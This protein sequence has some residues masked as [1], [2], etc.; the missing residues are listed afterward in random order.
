MST[1]RFAF[2]IFLTGSAMLSAGPLLV[3]LA[4]VDPL[5]SAFWR[6]GL[7]VPFL[8]ALARMGDRDARLIPASGR[9]WLVLAGFMFAADL[10]AWHLGIART[11][12][13]NSTILANSAAF[14]FPIWGYIAVRRGP[15][16][17][18]ALALIMAAVG[19]LLLV[20]QSATVSAEHVVGDLL[21][22]AA[23]IFYTFYLV[24]MDKARA[25]LGAMS[26]LAPATLAGAL[27]LLP[28]AY[29]APGGFWPGDWMPVILLALGSQVIGQGLI[30]Y[31]LPHLPPLASG[32]G[33]LVQ[34]VFAALL[35]FVWF[36]ETLAPMDVAG[37]TILFAAIII[38]RRPSAARPPVEKRVPPGGGG[39]VMPEAGGRSA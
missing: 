3:R 24:A 2:P 15:T 6:M 1:P 31:A 12:L 7:A 23:A 29:V 5:A 19:I 17:L 9:G 36:G 4:D 16:P 18:A 25:G 32:I 11:A 8:Y 37:I 21:C 27:F 14:L 35:G 38:V 10:A 22:F 20:G 26:A 28:V 33:L 39:G 13:A 34:P 30:I